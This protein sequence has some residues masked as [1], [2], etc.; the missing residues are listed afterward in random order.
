ML[1]Q[2]ALQ[3]NSVA[4]LAVVN[5]VVMIINIVGLIRAGHSVGVLIVIATRA[6]TVGL[7]ADH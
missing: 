5:R 4:S 1:A 7:V 3:R 6:T 2:R